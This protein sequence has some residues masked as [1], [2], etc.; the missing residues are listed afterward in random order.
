MKWFTIAS[1][2]ARSAYSGL[3]FRPSGNFSQP[4]LVFDFTKFIACIVDGV[5]L[6][7]SI[8]SGTIKTGLPE[9]AIIGKQSTRIRKVPCASYQ[10]K[11]Q[12]IFLVPFLF[13]AVFERVRQ[14][15]KGIVLCFIVSVKGI[16]SF[17]GT[18]QYQANHL[19]CRGWHALITN[20]NKCYT[21]TIANIVIWGIMPRIDF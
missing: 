1:R 7:R 10:S 2:T 15:R 21:L 8:P 11:R 12:E 4:R 17:V 3:F 19:F 9:W 20:S 5:V 16:K 13:G 14:Y 6:F 18:F